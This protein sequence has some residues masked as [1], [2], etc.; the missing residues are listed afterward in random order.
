MRVC[1]FAAKGWRQRPVS[2]SVSPD[3]SG[4]VVRGVGSARVSTLQMGV[5]CGV[6]VGSEGGERSHLGS[7]W[8]Y[9]EG[10]GRAHLDSSRFGGVGPESSLLTK[11]EDL[12]GEGRMTAS[13][14]QQI[15]G[16]SRFG[17]L[18]VC[19]AGKEWR[20]W[21]FLFVLTPIIVCAISFRE[22]CVCPSILQRGCG[23]DVLHL[24]LEGAV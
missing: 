14:G 23:P 19:T 16:F 7:I 12:E 24:L 6:P 20:R 4:C 17:S 2:V 21:S 3:C 5:R 13:G 22:G 11:K 1:S 15:F 10:D 8:T 9:R 18:G